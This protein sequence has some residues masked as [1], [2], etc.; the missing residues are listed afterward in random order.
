MFQDALR[1]APLAE[2]YFHDG[3]GAA[4]AGDRV[5]ALELL[6]KAVGL[7]LNPVRYDFSK[8]GRPTKCEIT[9]RTQ[10]MRL[11]TIKKTN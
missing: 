10:E 9:E 7:G 3:A 5:K 8:V 4:L 11:V 2:A 6:E 1:E